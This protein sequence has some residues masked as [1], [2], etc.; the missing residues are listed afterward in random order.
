MHTQYTYIFMHIFMYTYT[1]M[2]I[3][4]CTY[5]C[6]YVFS[7]FI[8]TVHPG[9]SKSMYNGA[10]QSCM[11]SHSSTESVRTQP[12][13][14]K[15]IHCHCHGYITLKPPSTDQHQS[16]QF[17]CRNHLLMPALCIYAYTV[18]PRYIAVHFS[19]LHRIAFKQKQ[20]VYVFV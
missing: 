6:I 15:Y 13:C 2:H 11:L 3:R 17:T 10:N 18:I 20:N 4:C 8:V 1:C 14:V 7:S 19:R 9:Y 5:M 12:G 16:K